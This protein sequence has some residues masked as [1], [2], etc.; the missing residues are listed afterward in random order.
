MTVSEKE[1]P[2]EQTPEK[3]KKSFGNTIVL[4]IVF[5]IIF[6]ALVT[7]VA[8][9]ADKLKRSGKDAKTT[10]EVKPED[11]TNPDSAETRS[12]TVDGKDNVVK[13]EGEKPAET[14]MPA[15]PAAKP[16]PV[17]TSPPVVAAKPEEHKPAEPAAK[18]EP[19][20]PAAP[21]PAAVAPKAEAPKAEAPKAA[22]PAKPAPKAEPAKPVAPKAAAPALAPTPK[23]EPAKPVVK[24]EP[25][26]PAVK[27]EAPKAEAK[28]VAKP[29]APKATAVVNKPGEFYVQLAS[30]KSLDLAK[31]EFHRMS[32]KVNDLQLVQVDLGDK[33]TWYRLRCG[34]PLPYDKALA[35][36]DEI[37]AKTGYKPDIMK[38]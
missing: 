10:E 14:A 35:R 19:V 24:A 12:F 16:E 29:V 13:Q 34:T 23:A 32:P 9:F 11:M 28:P 2:T 27:A 31:E 15:E 20:K 5:F 1:K 18:P 4:F 38:K 37:A 26:K 3:G 21:A 22:E 36:A 30:F 6:T 33:G 25:V 7:G 17:L 8:F